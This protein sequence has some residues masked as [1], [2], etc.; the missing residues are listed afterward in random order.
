MQLSPP[1][2]KKTML[3]NPTSV[4]SYSLPLLQVLKQPTY[5]LEWESYVQALATWLGVELPWDIRQW[6]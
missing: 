1:L 2:K 4:L 3:G 5:S 6:M